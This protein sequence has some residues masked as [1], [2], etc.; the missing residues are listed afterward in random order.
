[1]LDRE[2]LYALLDIESGRDFQ[3]FENLAA[4]FESDEGVEADLLCEL[5]ADVDMEVL[6]ELLDSYFEEL[7]G[8]LPAE[9]TALMS[10]LEQI[11]M[12]LMGLARAAVTDADEAQSR[13]LRLS[14]ELARFQRWYALESEVLCTPETGGRTER[15][16][17]RDAAFS[18]RAERLTSGGYLYDFSGCLDYPLDD[19]IVS[20]ADLLAAEPEGDIS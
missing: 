4:L 15:L 11:R 20:F 10:L 8:G 16:T 12:A 6:S 19:Y 2:R 17:L 7:E 18:T 9:E 14:E 1:M 3:Y 5:M 13:I